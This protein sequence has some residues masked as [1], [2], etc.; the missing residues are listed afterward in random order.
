VYAYKNKSMAYHHIIYNLVLYNAFDHYK[1]C[2][3]PMIL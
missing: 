3:H 1:R 2:N